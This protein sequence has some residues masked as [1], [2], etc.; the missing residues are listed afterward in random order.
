MPGHERRSLL[1]AITGGLIASVGAALAAPVMAFL[2]GPLRRPTVRGGD[3]PVPVADLDRLPEGTPVAA[4]VVVAER[5]DAWAKIAGVPLGAVWIVRRGD[6]VECL[7]STCPHAGCFVDWSAADN[8]FACPCHKS[9]FDLDGKV[10][11]GPSPRPM[12]A[13]EA[14]VKDGR[15]LVRYRRFRQATAKKEPV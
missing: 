14:E 7:S 5:I 6:R 10:I 15:V 3:E 2:G 1:K 13:L 12:D 9:A 8:R 11:A 4:R